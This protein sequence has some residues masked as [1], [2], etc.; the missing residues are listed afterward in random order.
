VKH[1][2]RAIIVLKGVIV[3]L[4]SGCLFVMLALLCRLLVRDHII[5]PP[6]PLRYAKLRRRRKLDDVDVDVD[7]VPTV[8]CATA[9]SSTCPSTRR[10]VTQFHI[11]QLHG[12]FGCAW[13]EGDELA[14]PLVSTWMH[15]YALCPSIRTDL[16]WWQLC[17]S[18]N[19]YVLYFDRHLFLLS[20]I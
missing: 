15:A 10:I 14:P 11:A 18:S 9:R 13:C 19:S 12:M 3:E 7:D 20:S 4:M 5:I 2:S 16:Y 17:T 1:A 6:L 8:D